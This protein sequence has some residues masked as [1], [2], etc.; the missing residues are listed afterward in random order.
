MSHALLRISILLPGSWEISYVVDEELPYRKT[1]NLRY[2][3]GHTIPS[4]RM[5][6]FNEQQKALSAN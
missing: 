2:F 5:S 4:H 1:N 6:D 3:G